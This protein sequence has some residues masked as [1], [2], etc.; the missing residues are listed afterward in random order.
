MT[1]AV[2]TLRGMRS[3]LFF[4][5]YRCKALDVDVKYIVKMELTE[6]K[7]IVDG[8]THWY[9][10]DKSTHHWQ[11]EEMAA[12]G[13]KFLIAFEAALTSRHSTLKNS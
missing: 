7:V 8:K 6:V 4:R 5:I 11:Q 13:L 2:A 3:K 12:F 1:I 10:L 9:Q